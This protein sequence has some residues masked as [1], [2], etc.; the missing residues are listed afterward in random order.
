MSNLGFIKSVVFADAH[1]DTQVVINL[2]TPMQLN[3]VGNFLIGTRFWDGWYAPTEEDEHGQTNLLNADCQVF[4]VDQ[5][6][7]YHEA[8]LTRLEDNTQISNWVVKWQEALSPDLDA[9][10]AY[11]ERLTLN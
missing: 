5:N 7:K 9:P 10:L 1:N 2:N 3:D 4:A 11:A 8:R 6:G